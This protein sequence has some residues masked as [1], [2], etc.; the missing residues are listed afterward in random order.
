MKSV[1]FGCLVLLSGCFSPFHTRLPTF[2]NRS[3]AEEKRSFNVHDPLPEKDVGPDTLVRPRGFMEQRSE[4]R[5]TLEGQGM[6]GPPG[7]PGSQVPPGGVE[8]PEVVP[9]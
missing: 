1:I 8:F 2:A 9:H 6:L 3:P 7:I 4:P 5:R